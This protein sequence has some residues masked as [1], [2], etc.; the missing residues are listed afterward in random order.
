MLADGRVLLESRLGYAGD[1][2]ADLEGGHGRACGHDVA[3]HIFSDDGRIG[4]IWEDLGAEH[5]EGPAARVESD[6][7]DLDHDILLGWSRIVGFL[8]LEGFGAIDKPGCSVERHT[9]SD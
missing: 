4:Q 7:L 9:G 8:D 2:V 6:A 3:G 5:F 1:T